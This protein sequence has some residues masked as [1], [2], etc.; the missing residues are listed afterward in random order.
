MA[1]SGWT[2]NSY[3]CVTSDTI[4]GGGSYPVITVTV[5]VDPNAPSSVTNMAVVTGG[6]SVVAVVNDVTAIH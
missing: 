5:N 3:A 4:G 1:G 2:C 6:G